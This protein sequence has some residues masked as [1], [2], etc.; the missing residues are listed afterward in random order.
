MQ[1]HPK[2]K[3]FVGMFFIFFFIR[4][5]LT[6]TIIHIYNKYDNESLTSQYKVYIDGLIKSFCYAI[7]YLVKGYIGI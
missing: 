3:S 6:V 1:I 4:H 2:I 7:A 5:L